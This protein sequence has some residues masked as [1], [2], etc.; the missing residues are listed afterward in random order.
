MIHVII[1]FVQII[2]G[3]TSAQLAN[4]PTVCTRTLRENRSSFTVATSYLS[5]AATSRTFPPKNRKFIAIGS[6]IKFKSLTSR[7]SNFVSLCF[8]N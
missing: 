8:D 5:K 7:E 4:G 6:K 3:Y 2:Y 1:I